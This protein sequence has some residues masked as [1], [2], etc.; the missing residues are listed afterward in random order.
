[1]YCR[2]CGKYLPDD[3][4]FC[5]SCGKAVD[6]SSSS[7]RPISSPKLAYGTLFVR[8]NPCARDASIPADIYV[9][10]A[11]S[12]YVNNGMDCQIR[13]PVGKHAVKVMI[14]NR[15]IG[16]RYVD[17]PSDGKV[18]IVFSADD[19]LRMEYGQRPIPYSSPVRQTRQPQKKPIYKRWW[20]WVLAVILALAF[21]G[22]RS[23]NQA[24]SSSQKSTTVAIKPTASP[25]KKTAQIVAKTPEPEK[26]P[27]YLTE[28][29]WAA[30]EHYKCAVEIDDY[31]GDIIAAGRY[32]AVPTLYTPGGKRVPIVW[33]IYVSSNSYDNI[34]QLSDSEYVT[35]VGGWDQ[36]GAEFTLEPGQYV[37][38]KYNDT[39]GEPSGAL[40][41]KMLGE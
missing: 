9:D 25:E 14:R 16:T 15:Y 32:A 28:V 5:N 1:M 17:I 34:S 38:I 3:S 36:L 7:V 19:V 13:L 27:E 31:D 22:S 39:V 33:D 20:F 29:V 11:K 30:L 24:G 26:D 18:E 2:Y 4:R 35:S 23:D 8:R 12:G 41:L 37:Y 6:S 10:E 21:L 40:Q